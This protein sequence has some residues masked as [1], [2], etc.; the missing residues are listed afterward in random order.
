M[1]GVADVKD[2]IDRAAAWGHPAS[3]IMPMCVFLGTFHHAHGVRRGHMPAAATAQQ[4]TDCARTQSL[5]AGISARRPAGRLD[6]P[7][8]GRYN[9][10]FTYRIHGTHG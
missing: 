4:K 2:L 1:D 9:T 7:Q 3:P 6:S 8:T 5:H 10:V